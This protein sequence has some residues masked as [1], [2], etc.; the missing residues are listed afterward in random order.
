MLPV[1]PA[2]NSVRISLRLT[3]FLRCD[4]ASSF[5]TIIAESAAEMDRL[6]SLWQKLLCQQ[7]HTL[8][9]RFS[10]NRLAA[11]MFSDRLAPH[12]VCA[13]SGRGAAIIP[14]A[15]NR[16][17]NRIELLG[18]TLFDYRDVLSAGD[19]EALDHAWRVLAV[20]RKPLRVVSLEHAAASARWRHFPAAPFAQAPRVIHNAASE[21]TFRLAHSRL[22][23]QIRRLQKQ[24]AEFHR[25]PGRN[26][27][28]V[29]RI[30][31]GKRIQFAGD[32]YDN[33]FLDRS[34]CEFMVAAAAMEDEACEVYTLQKQGDL[35]AG[36]VAFN[37]GA[38][39]RFY[40]TYFNPEWAH[41]SPGQALLYEATARALAEGLSCDYM[42]G[43][44]PYKLRLANESRPLLYVDI[45]A[46]QL[47]DIAAQ[48][49]IT[50]AA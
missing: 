27:Q 31:D 44:Y 15:I 47:A 42:T 50:N 45:S 46:E 22:G 14:A 37:D 20:Y 1:R 32:G 17:S 24:G 36:L 38:V 12:V 26:S 19:S 4:L 21:T 43:E 18:E 35:V 48:P 3:V 10:W 2:H 49:K 5:R 30:Y 40:T 8:F 29:R 6:E 41:Y 7:K 9:Q 34:R 28:L 33:V 23:R 39:R 13:E 11:E 25:S 16:V